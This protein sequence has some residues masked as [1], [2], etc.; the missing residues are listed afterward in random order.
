M[1]DL[2]IFVIL[3]SPFTK[4]IYDECISDF[5]CH[6]KKTHINPIQIGF[7]GHS[8]LLFMFAFSLR[9]PGKHSPTLLL[10]TTKTP[11]FKIPPQKF[12]RSLRAKFVISKTFIRL[13]QKT[14]KNLSQFKYRQ[15]VV[16]L[17]LL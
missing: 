1:C 3:E 15:S 6:K 10:E 13:Q 8:T 2:I 17:N 12:K 9:S 11:R 4:I 5:K 14:Q 7:C 16:L